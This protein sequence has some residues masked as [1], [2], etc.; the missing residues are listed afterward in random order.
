VNLEAIIKDCL[1]GDQGAWRMLVDLYSKKV[2]NMAYQFTGSR[3][4]AEDLTQDIF[5]KLYRSLD[6]FDLD[7]NFTAWLLAL[8]KHYL[9]DEYR[10]TKLEK[11]SRDDFED[12]APTLA[13]GD[14]PERGLAE[15]ETR[16]LLWSGLD[17]LPADI[18]LAVILKE[19]QGKTYEEVAEI[20]GVPIGT[21]KSRINRGRLQLARILQPAREDEHDV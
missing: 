6:K 20:S 11:R 15:A 19:I 17:R 4:E 21:V 12:V 5:M 7:K 3:E 13:G 1:E 8:A 9:I 2:F 10:R 16:R 14:D 18:R